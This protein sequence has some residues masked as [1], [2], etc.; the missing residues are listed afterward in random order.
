MHSEISPTLEMV[1]SGN[2]A[3]DGCHDTVESGYKK[4]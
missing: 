4:S 2:H 3:L 1:E